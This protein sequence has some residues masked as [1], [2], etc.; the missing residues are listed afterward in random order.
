MQN[1]Q[2]KLWKEV[3]NIM[4]E[5]M[6]EAYD[7]GTLIEDVKKEQNIFLS[8]VSKT[9]NEIEAKA[10]ELDNFFIDVG[11]PHLAT[12]EKALKTELGI[13]GK[14]EEEVE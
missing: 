12:N 13:R 8:E 7:Y 5:K 14:Y 9:L 3:Q 2:L 1:K 10:T 6:Y 4:S 11:L